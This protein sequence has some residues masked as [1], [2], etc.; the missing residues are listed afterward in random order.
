[1]NELQLTG[2]KTELFNADLRQQLDDWIAKYPSGQSQ[3]AVIPGLHLLQDENGGWLSKDIMD[4]LAVYLSMP[5]I[6]VYEVATFYSMYDLKPVGRHKIN[7][8]TNISCMLNGSE[9]IVQHLK[10]RL[11]V[12]FG[13]TTEDG[14]YTLKEVECLGACCGAPMLQLDRDYHEHLTTD[15]IDKIL[16][17]IKS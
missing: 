5:A 4:A 13:E 14:Q 6:S 8:C 3:S 11:G 16:D 17:G 1:M 2:A 15:K 7:V 9:E 10:K 12:G